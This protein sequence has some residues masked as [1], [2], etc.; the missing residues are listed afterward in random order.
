MES[1]AGFFR[2]WFG[3][4]DL[5]LFTQRCDTWQTLRVF[6]KISKTR[7]FFGDVFFR[8]GDLWGKSSPWNTETF[9]RKCFASKSRKSKKMGVDGVVRCLKEQ[10]LGGVESTQVPS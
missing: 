5:D 2:G 10:I 8:I 9:G 4:E 6:E 1:R 7:P 3:R